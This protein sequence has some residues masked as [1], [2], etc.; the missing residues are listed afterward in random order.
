MSGRPA[1][2]PQGRALRKRP[3]REG[4]EGLRLQ[5]RHTRRGRAAASGTLSEALQALLRLRLQTAAAA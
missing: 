2:R 4:V 3:V 5:I 1:L